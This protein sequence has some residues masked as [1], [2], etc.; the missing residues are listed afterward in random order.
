MNQPLFP[1]QPPVPYRPLAAMTLL[2]ILLSLAILGGTVAAIGEL[3]RAAFQ[4][5]R[6]ARDLVQAELLA[7]S[8]L[9]KIRLGIIEMENAFDVPIGASSTINQADI[10]LDTHALSDSTSYVPWIYSLEVVSVDDVLGLLEVAV[11]VRQN[12]PNNPR[13]VICRL[14]RW[15][16]LE[17]VIDED[18]EEF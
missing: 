2:E 18:E 11:M 13:A 15:I 17:P 5:A 8:V 1:C 14:V 9:V 3:A 6:L 16:A 4:D 7:E 10:V 12:E